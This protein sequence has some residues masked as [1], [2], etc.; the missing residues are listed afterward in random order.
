M[1]HGPCTANI[2]VNCKPP[3]MRHIGEKEGKTK[4]DKIRNKTTRMGLQIKH[5]KEKKELAQRTWFGHTLRMGVRVTPKWS[6]KLEQGILK[7]G[8]MEW[9][10]VRTIV[11]HCEQQKALCKPSTP[12]SRSSSTK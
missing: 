6:G 5:F 4:R 7:G 10:R 12:I 8:G 9:N 2:T 3:K 11:Q 1:N